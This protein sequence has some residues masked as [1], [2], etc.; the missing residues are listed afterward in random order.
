MVFLGSKKVFFLRSKTIKHYTAVF[1]K[2][3]ISFDILVVLLKT[4][5]AIIFMTGK[6]AIQSCDF[7]W[8]SVK[9][10][11]YVKNIGS[12]VNIHLHTMVPKLCLKGCYTRKYTT[13]GIKV[14]LK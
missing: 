10:K 3:G 9:F 8:Q 5:Y 6:A 14:T 1:A 13:K 11:K 4:Q 7:C 2:F 12:A